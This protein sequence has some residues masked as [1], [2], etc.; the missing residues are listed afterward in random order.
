MKEFAT[1]AGRLPAR[2]VVIGAS[3]GA[4]DALSRILPA[5][6]AG[7]P[8]PIVIVVHVPADRDSILARLLGAR[9]AIPVREV[10]D[11][12]PLCGGTVYVA[13]PD[14]HLLVER[15]G[16]LALSVDDPVNFSRPSIDV[17]FESAADAFGSGTVGVILTGASCDGA[18][19]LRAIRRAGGVTLVQRPDQS[20]SSLMPQS[21][22]DACPEARVGSL[23][24][25]AR[26][27]GELTEH[28]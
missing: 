2:A 28:P 3:A 22:L 9:C 16:H 17:L 15:T 10:E 19:G 7:F 21:A 14:Y 18:N 13:P 20:F 12:E 27:L 1:S 23:E 25:I 26:F 8:Y 11:K 24:E 5:V 4:L 6:P